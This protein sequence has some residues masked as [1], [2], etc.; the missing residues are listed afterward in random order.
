MATKV[1]KDKKGYALR[2]GECQ[3]ATGQ[4][5]FTYTDRKGIKWSIY[6]KSLMTLREREKQ[7]ILDYD[8]GLDPFAA[9]KITVNQLYEKYMS[10][11]YDL[12][13]TTKGN[14]LYIYNHFIRDTFGTKK[15]TDVK[16]SD[17]KSFYYS[18]LEEKKMKA[19]TLD[20][21]HC[22]LHPAFQMA[23]RDGLL[24]LNPTDGVMTE[25]KKGNYW[26]A[27]PRMALTR[28]EQ[29]AFMNFLE[30]DGEY[31]GW[32][33][34][35]TVLLGTGMRIGECL[36]LRWD[37]IDFESR[38]LSVNHNLTE[39]PDETGECRKHIQRVTK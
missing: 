9:K 20:S 38:I 36:G 35:I 4:Y 5:S 2:T 8:R 25:I 23:V 6:S 16:Y 18:F 10:Q 26:D 11:K 12:K 22:Q 19:N 27:P 39:R 32:V 1:R 14:Y 13:A 37:D 30:A 24:R 15:I 21:V 34:I 31:E 29:Q 17:V 33:P 28:P 3:R 7:L